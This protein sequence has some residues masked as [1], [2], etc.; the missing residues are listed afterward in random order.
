MKQLQKQLLFCLVICGSFLLWQNAQAACTGSSPTWTCSADSTAAEINSCITSATSG[1]TINIEAGTGTWTSQVTVDKDVTIQGAGYENTIITRTGTA[2][3][4]V[5]SSARVTGVGFIQAGGDTQIKI[6]GGAGWRIDHCRFDY[7]GTSPGESINIGGENTPETPYGLIDNN[8]FIG[9]RIVPSLASSVTE[10]RAYWASDHPFGTADTDGFHNIYVEDNTFFKSWLSNVLDASAYT[11]SYVARYNSIRGQTQFQ[12]HSLQDA[13]NRG[14]RGWEIYGNEFVQET[15]HSWNPAMF[16]RA[17]TGFAFFNSM[18]GYNHGVMFDNVRCNESIATAGKCDGT[19][20]W[21]GNV[22]ANGWPC[23]DQVG[24]GKDLSLWTT[25]NP[26]PEQ[27]SQPAYI[28]SNI[29]NGANIP[30]YIHN[31]NEAWIQPDRDYYEH[32]D[33]FDGTSGVG[34]GT[35]ANR[36]ATCTT[37]V[38]YWATDQSCTDLTGMVGKDPETPIEGTLYKCTATDTWT[39]YYTPYT[40]PHPLRTEASDIV[41][42]AAPSGLAVQ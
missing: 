17:G 38:G 4:L 12:V 3:N 31:N 8:D 29:Q 39:S 30:V 41:A 14:A 18:T 28:W 42:P 16:I 7:T 1:D 11:G 13:N 10:A 15:Y 23:R 6:Q 33:S 2:I 19:S 9:G 21:D 22:L 5:N 25:E 32:D 40:Y 35:L 37:G 36:P 20:D 27:A 34:C 26:N 24:R